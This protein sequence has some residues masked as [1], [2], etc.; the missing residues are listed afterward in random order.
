M[1]DVSRLRILVEVSRQGTMSAAAN[2][3]GY[4]PS[5]VS[6]Q[7]AALEREA[8]TPLVTRGP[9]GARLTEPGRVLV[10]HAERVLAELDA[11][12][13]PLSAIA[14]GGGGRL[15]FCSFV[16][17]NALLMPLAVAA[18]RERHPRVQLVLFDV[19]RDDA[20][21]LLRRHELDIALIYEFDV[22]PLPTL[23]DLQLTWLLDDPLHIAVPPGHRLATRQTVDLTELREETWI[24]GVHR[25]STIDVLPRACRAAGFEPRI[26]FR[27]DD[28]VTVHGLVAAGV[29][30][31]LMPLIAV[32]TTRSDLVVR[33][34]S[35]A[36]LTRR[37][38]AAVPADQHRLPS[39]DAM[40]EYLRATAGRTMARARSRL[41]AGPAPVEA[42]SAGP[43]PATPMRAGAEPVEPVTAGM[44]P[45]R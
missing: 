34:L 3:L 45:S 41:Q 11:A 33:A 36:S 28:Q 26:A 5:A 27:T 1:F 42:G 2:S 35:S 22:V 14:D 24:Q 23:P 12:D 9:R 44:E 37:I 19:D 10:W 39:A 38:Y 15:R 32:P 13:A 18:F 30:I 20:L 7:V 29:G 6:Q 31:A 16:T 25:G 21:S 17:A 43:E 8:G 40:V 4:T